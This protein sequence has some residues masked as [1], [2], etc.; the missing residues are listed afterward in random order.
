[1][2]IQ[3][4]MIIDEDLRCAGEYLHCMYI[5][6]LALPGEAK[7]QKKKNHPCGRVLPSRRSKVDSFNIAKRFAAAAAVAL[8]PSL[9]TYATLL[10]LP[11]SEQ[12]E[13][14]PHAPKTFPS[15]LFSSPARRR[16]TD[17]SR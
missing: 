6:H 4:A 15:Y 2:N 17:R 8:S 14:P 9:Y 7:K 12:S 1:M 13:S 11:P 3:E 10:P 5:H 16:R